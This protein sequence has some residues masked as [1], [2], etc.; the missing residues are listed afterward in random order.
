MPLPRVLPLAQIRDILLPSAYKL[1][2][3]TSSRSLTP[4][5]SPVVARPKRPRNS[6][7]PA[8]PPQNE[9]TRNVRRS[10]DYLFGDE[11]EEEDPEE[12]EE[13]R[14]RIKR[15]AIQTESSSIPS[16]SQSQVLPVPENAGPRVWTRAELVKRV[17]ASEAEIADALRQLGAVEMDGGV[18]L[19]DSELSWSVIDLILALALENE[20]WDAA[21]KSK[22]KEVE[23]KAEITAAMVAGMLRDTQFTDYPLPIVTEC[24]RRICVEREGGYFSLERDKVYECRAR[25]LLEMKGEWKARE[26][27]DVWAQLLPEGVTEA[28]CSALLLSKGVA[29]TLKE[30][31][32][33]V[34]RSFPAELLPSDPKERLKRLFQEQPSWT[35]EQME[36]FVKAVVP[37]NLS[38]EQ[39]LLKH[40][41]SVVQMREGKQ[42]RVFVTRI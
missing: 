18:R 11:E 13:R 9:G 29:L 23:G 33:D 5:A 14:E 30:G 26:F 17:R 8:P 42:T 22:E 15:R 16:S 7:A 19:I 40:T 24:L 39:F 6:E 2:P 32:D 38:T 31:Q 4:P 10:L 37:S 1:P 3:P 20:W 27:Y 34:I 12:L 21:E 41:R 28:Q 35:I 25:Q 36:P